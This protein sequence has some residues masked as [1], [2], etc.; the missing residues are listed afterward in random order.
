MEGSVVHAA[1]S[2]RLI[3]IWSPIQLGYGNHS[4]NP[5][6]YS[7]K[8]FFQEMVLIIVPIIPKA[9]PIARYNHLVG[10]GRLREDSHQKG[11][12]SHWDV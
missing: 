4:R 1:S 8:Y 12:M 6:N 10:S 2:R 3:N 7:T 5:G 11:T 9:G